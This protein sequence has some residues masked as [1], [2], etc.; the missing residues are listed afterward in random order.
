L[1]VMKQL[2]QAEGLTLLLVEQNS[3]LALDISPRTVVMNR[4]RIVYDG[5]SEALKQDA[6]RLDQLIGL[7]SV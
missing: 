1:R 4:G 6:A 2:A 7:A 5:P 3:R